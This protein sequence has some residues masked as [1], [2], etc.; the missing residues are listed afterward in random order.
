VSDL[1]SASDKS[2]SLHKESLEKIQRKGTGIS[3]G[4][5]GITGQTAYGEKASLVVK[6]VVPL[7]GVEPVR[8][9]PVEGF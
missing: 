1:Q 5:R 7:T 3:T 8:R 2:V 9:F 4:I 6:N